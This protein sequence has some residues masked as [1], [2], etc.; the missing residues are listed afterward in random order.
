[1]R[2]V[3]TFSARSTVVVSNLMHQQKITQEAAI[4]LS[5]HMRNP[6]HTCTT[7]THGAVLYYCTG[8][9][10]RTSTVQSSSWRQSDAKVHLTTVQ[11]MMFNQEMSFTVKYCCTVTHHGWGGCSTL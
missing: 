11:Y 8:V 4:H 5:F 9:R 6:L 10:C 3:V 2:K 1:M 7:L